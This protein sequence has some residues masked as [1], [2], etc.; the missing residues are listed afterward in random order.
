MTVDGAPGELATA[1]LDAVGG[2]GNVAGL[3]R[4]YSR[5]RFVLVDDSACDDATLEAL[6]EVVAV[7][8]RGGQVQVALR[9]GLT[10]TYDAV[11]GRLAV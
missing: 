3:T 8:R 9:S 10:E 6:P 2:A 5:L 7:L 11:R 4:C 1:L